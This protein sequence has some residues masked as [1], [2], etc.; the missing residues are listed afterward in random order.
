MPAWVLPNSLSRDDTK[1]PEQSAAENYKLGSNPIPKRN[2]NTAKEAEMAE[3]DRSTWTLDERV[4]HERELVERRAA[5]DQ[6]HARKQEAERLQT[7]REE[8][9]REKKLRLDSWMENGG[10]PKDFD[11][12]WPSMQTAIREERYKARRERAQERVEDLWS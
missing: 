7:A 11:R 5:W 4:A 10:D 2:G 6:E 1:R 12:A 9:D 8:L 3:G